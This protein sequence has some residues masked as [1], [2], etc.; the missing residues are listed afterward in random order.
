MGGWLV[1][2]PLEVDRWGASIWW[3]G[4][5]SRSFLDSRELG[6]RHSRSHIWWE[7]GTSGLAGMDWIWGM[8]KERELIRM[9]L[10]LSD[11]YD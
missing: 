3:V 1:L 9:T 10:P 2:K 4:G 5:S 8:M 7:S 6:V 11:L